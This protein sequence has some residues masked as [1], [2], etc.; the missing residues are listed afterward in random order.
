[1]S[2][3]PPPSLTPSPPDEAELV[4]ALDRVRAALPPTPAVWSRGR[5]AW[6]KL[7]NLQATGSYKVRG[8]LNAIAAQVERG[9]RRAVVV[10]SAGNHGL[11]AAWAARHFGLPAT[12][13][14]PEGA[15]S[16]KVRACR[17]LGAR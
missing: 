15:P 9:D 4:R 16:N 13:V 3:C 8:A 14:V 6:L 11:G 17:R 12:V 1:M 10:A 5:D 7:E 2:S